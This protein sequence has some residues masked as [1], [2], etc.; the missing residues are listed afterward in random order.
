MILVLSEVIRLHGSENVAPVLALLNQVQTKPFSKDLGTFEST[1]L[2][3][4]MPTT[5]SA[6]ERN[7]PTKG[8][9]N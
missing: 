4:V 8:R 2:E 7:Q 5:T 1:C 3:T 6:A 9:S